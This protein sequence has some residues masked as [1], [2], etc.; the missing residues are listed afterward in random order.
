VLT[1]RN[2]ISIT[3]AYV[4]FLK[5][6]LQKLRRHSVFRSVRGGFYTLEVTNEGKGWH[7]HFHLLV[8]ARYVDN[9]ELAIRWG[10]LVGQDF[11]IVKVKDC[12][13]SDYLREVTK[14]AVKGSE[15]ARWGGAAIGEF[16]ESF[17]GIRLFGVFGN[18]YGKRTEWAAWIES[19]REIKPLCTC[20]CDSWRLMSPE[21]LLWEQETKAGLTGTPP[22][23]PH[24]VPLNQLDM[25]LGGQSLMG[26]QL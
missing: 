5:N 18:L 22:P 24:Q 14:Y 15:L 21:E 26:W 1:V 25:P 6:Q 11:A 13:G 2:T 17:T 12:R 16:I 4:Q 7:I 8:D 10:K 19:I 9:G 3:K 23:L 20:G